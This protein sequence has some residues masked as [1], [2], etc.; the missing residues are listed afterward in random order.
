MPCSTALALFAP[1]AALIAALSHQS[2]DR[3][4]HDG[5]AFNLGEKKLCSGHGWLHGLVESTNNALKAHFAV[6]ILQQILL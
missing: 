3:P 1:G 6:N 4:G 2:Q 5:A